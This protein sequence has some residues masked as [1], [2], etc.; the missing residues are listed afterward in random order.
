M[1]AGHIVGGLLTW[2]GLLAAILGVLALVFGPV[3]LAVA[4]LARRLRGYW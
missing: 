2:L 3:V 1:T 4:R